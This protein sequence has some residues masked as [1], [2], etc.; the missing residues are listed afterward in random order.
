M[1]LSPSF[2]ALARAAGRLAALALLV[3][4]LSVAPKRL[5][6]VGAPQRV[7]TTNPKIGVHTRLTDEVEEW[8]VQRTL[9][10]V[11]EMGSPWIVEYFPWAYYEPAKGRYE[12]AHADMVVDHAVAQGLQVIARIDYVPEWARPA[13]TTARYLERER[14]ADYA[15]FVHAFVRHFAGRVRHIVIWNEPNLA[16]EWG[17]RPPDPAAY[18]ELLR[19]AYLRA[20]EADP[21]VQV[22]AAGLAPTLAPPGSEWGMDDLVFLQRLYDAGAAPFFDGLAIHAYGLTFPADEPAAPDQINFSRARLL[23]DVMAA[24][25]DAHKRGYITEGGWNDHPRWTKAVRPY[26]RIEYTVRAYEMALAEWPW[27]EAVCLWAFRYPWPQQTFQ[28]YYAFVTPEFVPK[29]VYLDTLH[30]ARGEAFEF[31]DGAP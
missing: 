11:H 4:C 3:Y 31:L 26:Q 23:Y 5:V 24:N 1:T 16:F 25:G 2:G 19:A 12:W 15:D 8:K 22:L 27:C 17:Y 6:V 29:P 10:M 7:I 30:Y 18:A 9:E 28:D 21:D 13:D 14:Y 20:K